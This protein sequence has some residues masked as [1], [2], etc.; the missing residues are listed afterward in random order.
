MARGDPETPLEDSELVA[1]FRRLSASLG[2]SRAEAIEQAALSVD[3]LADA[4]PLLDP[5]LRPA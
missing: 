4:R 1:K 2:P 5:V 3:E